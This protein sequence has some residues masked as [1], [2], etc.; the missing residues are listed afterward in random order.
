[1]DC[2]QRRLKEKDLL[3]EAVKIDIKELLA[4]GMQTKS[5]VDYLARKYDIN[6][7]KLYQMAL[8]L[9]VED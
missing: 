3:I 4:G 6:K 1:M 9:T 8:D 7:N 2:S 5:I